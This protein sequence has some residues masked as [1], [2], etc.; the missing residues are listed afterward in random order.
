[1]YYDW[2]IAQYQARSN[3]GKYV[4]GLIESG[5]G[6]VLINK[7]RVSSDPI[8]VG[9]KWAHTSALSNGLVKADPVQAAK[10]EELI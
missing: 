2:V 10:L 6:Y 3:K 7:S 1:M 8:I 9:F 5:V 4:L